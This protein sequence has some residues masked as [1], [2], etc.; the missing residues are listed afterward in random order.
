MLNDD[1][2]EKIICHRAVSNFCLE[3]QAEIINMF[4][5]I[6]EQIK[7]DNPYVTVSELLNE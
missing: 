3:T 4:E 2:L 6:L 1:I 5:E 7:E